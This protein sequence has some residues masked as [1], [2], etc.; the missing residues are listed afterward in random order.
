MKLTIEAKLLLPLTFI[1]VCSCAKSNIT[2]PAAL[3]IPEDLKAQVHLAEELGVTL[4]FLD[5][6]STI[7]TDAL[8]QNV[9][10]I[11]KL[12]LSGYL[13]FREAD[14]SGQPANSW[15]VFF[16]KGEVNPVVVYT[17][18]VP[19][20]LGATYSF[21]EHNPPV[22]A[23]EG[24]RTFFTARQTAIKALTPV[25]QPINPVILPGAVIGDDG[26]LVYLLAGET[27]KGVAVLGKHYRVLVSRDGT[28]VKKFE[29]LSKSIIEIPYSSEGK[30]TAGLVV[31]HILTDW[32]LETHVFASLLYKL[33][34][35]V[36]TSRGNWKVEKGKISLV[37]AGAQK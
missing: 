2:A 7:G 12:G 19:L 30:T 32:P 11:E 13:T 24:L 20:K 4:Y 18:R 31:S 22:P 27:R 1:V 35:Y 16:L 26:I 3:P 25:V 34:V 8:R 9:A 15:R 37:E 33:P 5:K 14:D 21:E 36:A 17:V 29:P 23:N 28:A 6:A 10:S